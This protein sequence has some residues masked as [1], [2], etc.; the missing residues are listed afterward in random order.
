MGVVVSA[1]PSSKSSRSRFGTRSDLLPVAMLGIALTQYGVWS[2]GLVQLPPRLWLDEVSPIEVDATSASAGRFIS[3][4]NLSDNALAGDLKQHARY[5]LF[6]LCSVS[7][8]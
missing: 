3:N 2:A 8:L 7:C 4:N 5:Y 6:D 1:H